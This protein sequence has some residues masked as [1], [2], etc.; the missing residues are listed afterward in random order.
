V[1]KITDCEGAANSPRIWIKPA[2]LVM[3]SLLAAIIV[4][5]GSQ[6]DSA[7]PPQDL[8]KTRQRLHELQAQM[9]QVDN[10]L[11]LLRRRRHGVLA[12]LQGIALSASKAR[13]MAEAARLNRD[14]ALREV[15]SLNQ[16]KSEIYKELGLLKSSLRRQVRWLHA[17][18]PLAAL[19]FLPSNADIENYLARS[20]YLDWWRKNETRKLLKAQELH[21][22]LEQK[23]KEIIEAEAKFS[24]VEAEMATLQDELR[25][26]ERKLYESLG[27]IQKD[28]R[29]K[30]EMQ[31]ELKEESILLERMLASVL[32]KAS[33]EGAYAASVPFLSL[34]GRLRSPVEGTLAEGFGIQTHPRYG[35]KTAN[36]GIIIAAQ[37]GAAVRAV[38]NG[39]VKLADSFQSYGLMVIIDHGNSYH[40][41]YQHLR[42]LSVQVDQIVRSGEVIGYVGD[43]PDGPRL[44]FEIRN[45]RTPE[46]PQRWLAVKYGSGKK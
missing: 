15:Q 21:A 26:S 37:G 19:A 16:R 36:T 3:S 42:A 28:E 35:T 1:A 2:I 18:G 10:Q 8:G 17:T 27:G 11:K 44:G 24:E 41:L 34:A 7:Q 45:V 5:A 46:D 39:K 33:P 22:E 14:Q 30:K 13:A 32:S 43:T 38:A 20:R 4:L 23:E 6:Q 9:S 31:A 40:T 12:E 25:A 29:L